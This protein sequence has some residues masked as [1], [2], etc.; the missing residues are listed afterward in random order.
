MSFCTSCEQIDIILHRKVVVAFVWVFMFIE[1]LALP[2]NSLS[3]LQFRA[4]REC[5]GQH[6]T[7]GDSTTLRTAAAP[8]NVLRFFVFE[9]NMSPRTGVAARLP[10]APPRWRVPLAASR[11][12]LEDVVPDT[13]RRRIELTRE[14]LDIPLA[15]DALD[16][17]RWGSCARLLLVPL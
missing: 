8:P 2:A 5:T 4:E 17:L 15:W 1:E 14:F 7:G 6:Y 12:D 11:L 16:N 9:R 13:L 3:V 10:S